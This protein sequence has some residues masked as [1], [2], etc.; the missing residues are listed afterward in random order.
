METVTG[1]ELVY[2]N[3]DKEWREYFPS[4]YMFMKDSRKQLNR[5]LKSELRTVLFIDKNCS[6]NNLEDNKLFIAIIIVEDEP[7]RESLQ[8]SFDRMPNYPVNIL[9]IGG[10][11]TIDLAKALVS[12]RHF[13]EPNLRIGYEG[14]RHVTHNLEESQDHLVVI[15]TTLGSGSESS[16]YSVL[17]EEGKKMPSRAWQSIPKIV[18]FDP[19]ELKYLNR[20]ELNIQLFDAWVHAFESS[21]ARTE[22]NPISLHLSR[23]LPKKII[24]S[25]NS[26]EQLPL[27]ENEIVH[28]QSLS[29]IAGMC[30]SNTRTG[31]IHTVGE[32]LSRY[33]KIPH[34]WTLHLASIHYELLLRGEYRETSWQNEAPSEFEIREIVNSDLSTYQNYLRNEF[35]PNLLSALQ[36]QKLNTNEIYEQVITDRVLFEK[37]HPFTISKEII[38]EYIDETL[39]YIQQLAQKNIT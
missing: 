30:I 3:S 10:G 7:T 23:D 20:K 31:I 36:V 8:N 25:L 13:K 21:I 37:E 32:I 14:L 33:L 26:P 29:T 15:P 4:F 28:F 27:T 16:R 17:F 6:R 38:I 11:A 5:I 9:A 19:M 2:F 24:M 39:K 35:P 18:V 34:V 22:V 1:L 12:S